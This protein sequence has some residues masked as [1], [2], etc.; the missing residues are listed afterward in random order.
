[1]ISLIDEEWR[2]EEMRRTKQERTPKNATNLVVQNG[3]E[4]SH[5]SKVKMKGSDTSIKNSVSGEGNS[6]NNNSHRLNQ[7]LCNNNNQEAGHPPEEDVGI[8]GKILQFVKGESV[9]TDENFHP[10]TCS[11]SSTSRKLSIPGCADQPEIETG[12]SRFSKHVGQSRR[13]STAGS[14]SSGTHG[15]V[16]IIVSP[17][18]QPTKHDQLVQAIRNKYSVGENENIIKNHSDRSLNKNKLE[19]LCPQSSFDYGMRE[20]SVKS[21]GSISQMRQMLNERGERVERMEAQ[22][23][24]MKNATGNMSTSMSKLAEK[25][26]NKKWYEI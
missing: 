15:S 1:M 20:R 3:C 7:A 21:V 9:D 10:R 26:K 8:V 24:S 23:E 14:M 11:M 6:H 19:K 12:N 5:S 18:N 16:E 25:Y 17:T 22:S 2:R 4:S 13:S